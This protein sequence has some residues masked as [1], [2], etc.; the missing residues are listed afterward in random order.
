M[1]KTVVTKENFEEAFKPLI[2]KNVKYIK[3]E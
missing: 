1:I 2:G 3:E